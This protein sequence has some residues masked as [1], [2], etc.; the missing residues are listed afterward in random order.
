MKDKF[1]PVVVFAY[2]RKWHL[3]QCINSLLANA[4]S[5]AIDLIIYVDGSRSAKDEDSVQQVYDYSSSI[6]GF[7]SIEI[8]KNK[9]NMGLSKSIIRGVTESLER[10]GEVIVLEDDVIVSKY[11]IDYMSKAL[12]IYRKNIRVASIHAYTY[13]MDLDGLDA[14][15]FFLMGADCW[16]WATWSRAWNLFNTDANDLLKKLKEKKITREFDL[17][18]SYKYSKMLRM[19]LKG[20]LDTWAV[21]WHASCYVNNMLTLYPK[22]SLAKNI[23]NDSTGTHS[24]SYE[25]FD[26]SL[27][28]QRIKFEEIEIKESKLAR[29]SLVK[30][31]KFENRIMRKIYKRI[32]YHIKIFINEI[33]PL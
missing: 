27:Y 14:E 21:R 18:G 24:G 31:F 8:N 7:K 12:D 28:D 10:Y 30:F 11:F 25:T 15:T 1:P 4:E 5:P 9:K 32:I 26:V 6:K 19:H 17:D 23:G 22:Y 16:G 33:H 3:E 2:K 20:K 29:Q 13:P